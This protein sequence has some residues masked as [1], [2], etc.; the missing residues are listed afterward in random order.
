M[1]SDAIYTPYALSTLYVTPYGPCANVVGH[2][3][4]WWVILII[5]TRHNY[6]ALGTLCTLCILH[7]GHVYAPL[8]VVGHINNNNCPGTHVYSI[9]AM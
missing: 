2:V 1:S 4:M 3:P 8:N 7:M 9:W 5:T 6:Y